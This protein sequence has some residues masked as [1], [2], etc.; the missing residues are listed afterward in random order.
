MPG[1]DNHRRLISLSSRKPEGFRTEFGRGRFIGRQLD[2]EDAGLLLNSVKN[3][4]KVSNQHLLK[5]KPKSKRFRDLFMP[6]KIKV[7]VAVA[8][9][10]FLWFFPLFSK[11]IMAWPFFSMETLS[12][13]VLLN[14]A[15]AYVA[16]CLIVSNLKDKKV[17]MIVIVAVV[18]VYFLIPKIADY[19]LGDVG[20]SKD[21]YCDCYGIEK[22]TFDCC[23]SSVNYCWG[24]CKR[25]EKLYFSEQ[26]NG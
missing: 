1:Y 5:M 14:L 23:Y 13:S 3:I 12:V 15:F 4:Y 21:I 18:L 7:L 24:I 10:I 16:G 6:D 9:A 11:S 8:F 22:Y 19:S 17:L 20:A 2:P 25:S 26:F